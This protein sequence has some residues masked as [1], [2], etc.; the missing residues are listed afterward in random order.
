MAFKNL[1]EFLALLKK[2]KSGGGGRYQAL[3]PAH[4]DKIPS[5]SVALDGQNIL[6]KCQAG[7]ST[8]SIVKSLNLTLRD[9]F[10]AKE[11]RKQ[12]KPRGEIDK[13]YQY[14]DATGKLIYEVVRFKP[15][16]FRQRRPDGK[17]GYFWN[18][19]GI[20]PVLYHLPEVIQAVKDQQL[21]WN[22]EGEKD[23]ES[24]RFWGLVATTNSGGAGKW[25]NEFS[26]HFI[27]ARVILIPDNDPPGIKHMKQ[28]GASLYG[29]AASIRYLELPD[30]DTTDWIE[31][32]HGTREQIEALVSALPEWV[33]DETSRILPE[34][35]VSGAR[36]R[37]ITNESLNAL[38]AIND[39]PFLFVRSGQMV[40]ISRD[41]HGTPIIEGLDESSLRGQLERAANYSK[42]NSKDETFPI[43]PPI[44][45]VRDLKSLGTWPFPALQGITET[46][47]VRGDGSILIDSG[48]DEITELYYVPAP[49]LEIPSIP[50]AP[51][52]EEIQQAAK[53][54]NETICDFPFE[55]DCSRTNAVAAIT[56]PVLRPLVPG[57]TPMALY[58]KPRSGTGSSLLADVTS[59]IANGRTSAVLTAPSEDEDWRKS[60]TSLLMLGRN[61]VT[62]DNIE[63]Q[64]S[65][66]SLSAVL[67]SNSWQDRI[68]GHSQMI[69]LPHR[70]SWIGTGN[71]IRLAGD[72]PRRCFWVRMD[73]KEARPWQRKG[74]RHPKL[75]EWITQ[76]R[77]KII[78]AILTLAR[79][80]ILAG[81]PT[82][83]L[84]VLGSFEGWVETVG[85][86]LAFAGF[87]GFLS[88]LNQMYD[89]TDEETPQWEQFISVWHE[90]LD[91]QFFT[92]AEIAERIGTSGT[93][94]YNALPL[95][96]IDS[97]KDKKDKG[98]TR[99]LGRA[100]AERSGVRYLN[101][102]MIE[103]GKKENRS[104]LWRVK[105]A[106]SG[107]SLPIISDKT[108]ETTALETHRNSSKDLLKESTLPIISKTTLPIISGENDKI[109]RFESRETLETHSP[110]ASK[111]SSTEFLFP[112]PIRKNNVDNIIIGGRG[113]I[114]SKNSETHREE[115]DGGQEELAEKVADVSRRLGTEVAVAYDIWNRG[116]APELAIG[117][118]VI[119]DL[120]STLLYEEL[121]DQEIEK[122]AKWLK[123]VQEDA[124]G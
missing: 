96:L 73:A 86:I 94:L 98:F 95:D 54:V 75:I 53:F 34:I 76:N 120:G 115:N 3:C 57:P 37:E 101:G 14:T 2:V 114:N 8:E 20:T 61:V 66:P 10:L 4:D 79:G 70:V 46:P 30:K 85:N 104:I 50:D 25:K 78:V 7:C 71:N 82:V 5:L 122:L 31:K 42:T 109:P 97:A 51:T 9:L 83:E 99:R 118:R 47:V 91:E 102:L 68:L 36:L 1:G 63:G 17:G 84:P 48:Y 62:I 106:S 119:E 16:S 90:V 111:M 28:V 27:G 72:L 44:D 38:V 67:T 11:E 43:P 69:I 12:N 59:L 19:E 87:E 105:V 18:L 74:F 15:K 77:G 117:D 121:T 124:S 60:I 107:V 123:I 112:T 13:V 21:I 108:D 41:E 33:P 40:R 49:G 32:Q 58:D 45:V 89:T 39:P 113:G 26:E 80:W 103:R 100:L 64:L 56:T 29:K 116:G 52:T 88:N 92:V 35:N 6:V 93:V 65:S 110:V 81:K 55:D 23:V 24:L 22:V